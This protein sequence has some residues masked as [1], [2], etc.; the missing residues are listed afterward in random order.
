[1]S[2][3]SLPVR[4]F[5]LLL[6]VTLVPLLVLGQLGLVRASPLLLIVVYVPLVLAASHF[7]AWPAR[8]LAQVAERMRQG[9]L[10]ARP[11][12][13]LWPPYDQIVATMNQLATDLDAAN[14]HFELEVNRRTQELTRKANQ[15]RAM[16]QV[17]RQVAAVLEP[18]ELLH[19]VVRVVRGT[20][21]Y[22]VVAIVQEE[23]EHLV[24]AAC[25]VR[26]RAD[27][28]LGR[29]FSA[30]APGAAT[31]REGMQGEGNISH[32]PCLL[33]EGVAVQS[34]LT[35]P[36]RMGARTIGAMVVQSREA[37]A[38][39]DDDMFTVR[40]IAGQVAVALENARLF[41]AERELRGLAIT[42]ERT[43]IAR[44]IHDTLA[45]HFMGILMHLR[46]MQGSKDAETSE[47]H[48]NQAEALAQEGLEEARR[49]VWNLRPERLERRGLEGAILDEVE[50]LSKRAGLQVDVDVSGDVD[51]VPAA[52]A[53]G[54][55]R[56]T[57]ES[58]HNTLRHAKARQARVRLHVTA[59][60]VE[61]EV[62]D[63][64][65][66]FDPRVPRAT[67]HRSGF[68]LSGMRER[69]HMLGGEL[70]IDSAPGAGTRIYVR[71]PRGEVRWNERGHKGTGS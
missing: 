59:D 55:L 3:H 14:R 25:A 38:F 10:G 9:E 68:G 58:L 60:A 4:I 40:T 8:E 52:V 66:G 24:L 19:F 53:A 17:G 27:V 47:M 42:E 16:G 61:L 33:V 70:T 2:L 12:V 31:L 35:V 64:G 30:R 67:T 13:R 26:G 45:Q 37:T 32:D 15:L 39:D 34:Q 18:S 20:F 50:R 22:D 63:D 23:G 46:A 28:P 62:R 7:L 43:R 36:I 48:R 29:V 1:M 21:S 54:L 11:P 56:I 71:I 51:A 57:Q 49:S 69:A 6:G 65:V 41:V 5:V 44:E